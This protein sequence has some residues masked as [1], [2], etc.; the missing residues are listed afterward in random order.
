MRKAKDDILLF[1]VVGTMQGGRYKM[2]SKGVAWYLHPDLGAWKQLSE[3]RFEFAGLP[4]APG[5]PN[6]TRRKSLYLADM[7]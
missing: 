5:V 1:K 2:D 3:G 7:I 6:F 4:G